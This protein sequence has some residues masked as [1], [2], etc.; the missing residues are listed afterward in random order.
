M[1]TFRCEYVRCGKASC[2]SCPHGPYWY[3]YWREG[4]R[5][6]KRYHGKQRPNMDRESSPAQAA[7]WDKIFDRRTA[8]TELALRILGLTDGYTQKDLVERYRALS[9]ECHP[10]RGGDTAKMR[11]VNAAYTFLR[12]QRIMW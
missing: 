8:T 2:R 6:R 3:E 9:L 12:S 7:A 4:G 5:L 1:A 11:H 10:D